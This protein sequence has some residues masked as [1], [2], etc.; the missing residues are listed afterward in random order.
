MWRPVTPSNHP[1]FL[2]NGTELSNYIVPGTRARYQLC[3]IRTRSADGFPDRKY[4]VRDAATVSDDDV[5]EGK[6][7]QIVAWFAY[8]DSAL[9]F[10]WFGIRVPDFTP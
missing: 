10:C 7:S 5:R 4:A 6:R 9:N 8:E 1:K 3:E 2:V